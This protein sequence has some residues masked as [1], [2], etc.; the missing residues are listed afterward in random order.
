MPLS[1]LLR[2]RGEKSL[3]YREGGESDC[4]GSREGNKIPPCLK[5]SF[6]GLL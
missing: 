5:K 4:L 2:V 6:H 1:C 3:K